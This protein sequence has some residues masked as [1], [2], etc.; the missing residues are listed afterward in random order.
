MTTRGFGWPIAIV[1]F[2][3]LLLAGDC[4]TT[5]PPTAGLPTP[6]TAARAAELEPTVA[7]GIAVSTT[8]VTGDCR[9][10]EAGGVAV[11]ACAESVNPACSRTRSALRL[12]VVPTGASVPI[13]PEC[14]GGFSA[15]GA[16]LVAVLDRRSSDAGELVVYLPDGTYRLLL[17]ADDRCAVCGL[18]ADGGPCLIDVFDGKISARD[19]LLD[20]ASR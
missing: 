11:E 14:G 2:A 7:T 10:I 15:A 6:M 9:P 8:H 3:P 5:C 12:L 17:T 13:A 20:E 1:L 19:L 16:A 4:G 18:S